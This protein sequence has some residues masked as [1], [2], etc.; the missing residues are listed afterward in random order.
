MDL[1]APDAVCDG[2]DLDCG[3]GL[4]LIIRKAI[5]PLRPGQVLEIR[6]REA[7]VRED[8]PAWCRMVEHD[9]LGAV[10]RGSHTSYFVRRGGSTPRPTSHPNL[11]DDLEKARSFT[12]SVRVRPDGEG[13]CRVYA[14]NQAYAVG[15][16]LD[17]GFGSGDSP[18]SALEHLLG[19]LGACL[20]V[21]YQVHASRVGVTLDQLELAIRGNLD[22]PLVYLGLEDAGHSG[23]ARLQGTIYVSA[24]ADEAVLRRVW[25]TTLARSPVATTLRQ[26]LP[27]DIR[28]Q[29][30][31]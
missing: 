2:G 18:L 15:Q 1:P 29:V 23:L 4:L 25:E 12:W 30:E 17:F 10:D 27:L 5:D 3:N 22:N 6:S 8:L 28:L 19:S 16:P 11:E 24:D 14:R 20:L 7:S 13:R 31:L 26:T 21:G 9:L